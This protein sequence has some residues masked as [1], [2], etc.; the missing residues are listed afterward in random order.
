[1][2]VVIKLAMTPEQVQQMIPFLMGGCMFLVLIL[3]WLR[4]FLFSWLKVRASG[5]SKVLV[6]VR[7]DLHNY[8]RVG[9]LDKSFLYFK[10][11][12]RSDSKNPRSQLPIC[13][14]GSDK[15]MLKDCM[16]RDWGV[17]V[18]EVD[19]MKECFLKYKN[20]EY[21]S[22]STGNSE[23]YDLAIQ[24]A[25]MQP[26]KGSTGIVDPRMFQI[27]MIGGIVLL[28]LGVGYGLSVQ[29]NMMKGLIATYNDVGVVKGLLMN[30]T[31]IPA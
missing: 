19:D 14:Q 23:A 8:Y 13:P 22:L 7:N 15:P 20:G 31:S 29:A 10:S 21:E 24:K 17:N 27:I 25:L 2:L 6:R 3:F 4:D 26:P 18:V 11:R 30:M 28:A 12:K 9:S 1:M 5:G 16:Y